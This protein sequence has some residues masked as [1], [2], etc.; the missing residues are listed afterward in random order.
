MNTL[1]INDLLIGSDASLKEA[2]RVIDKNA[3]GTAFVI[4]DESRLVGVVTDGDIRRALLNGA[5][6][7]TLASEVMRT[8]FTSRPVETDNKELVSLLNAKIRHIP[9]V[10][11]KNQPVDY[12]CIHHLRRIQVMEPVLD[13]NELE[14]VTDCIKTNWISSQGKYVRQFEEVFASY[15][16]MPYGLAV[17]NGTVA[18]HL[19]LEALGVGPGDE[20]I[21]PD[22]TFAATINA[23]LYTGA[24]PVLV[25]IEPIAW[26]ID[27]KQV[28]KAITKKTK[29]IIPVHLYGQACQMDELRKIAKK[30]SLFIV[31]DCAEAIGTLYKGKSV[32]SFG[33]VSAFS[34]FGNKT[35]TTGE[36]GMLLFK[37]KKLFERASV[38]RDHGMSKQKKYWHDEVGY[39]YRMT[40]LQ[41]AIGVAQM[42]K[43]VEFVGHKKRLGDLYNNFFA[44]ADKIT[45]PAITEWSKNSYWLY[46]ILL[47]AASGIDRDELIRKMLMNGIETRPAFFPLHK[48]PP[49]KRFARGRAF[50]VSCDISSRGINL[51]SSV[52]LKKEEIEEICR[53]LLS[54]LEIRSMVNKS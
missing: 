52:F 32:G 54:M 42:E 1:P 16:S 27:T 18:L 20:V 4:D 33:D 43:V 22:L 9:L 31:E 44:K 53:T 46:T 24:T 3:Q 35:I 5:K 21:V 36:G 19:A 6:L 2:M 34:F 25:D 23:V 37:D 14:Y 26:T 28:E 40:N 49:Y 50:P 13:G 8:Q 38:L 29:A 11:K 10:N 12:A 30:H 48:M 51:P 17:S 7:T 15:C 45:T 39:N 41:A 47:D